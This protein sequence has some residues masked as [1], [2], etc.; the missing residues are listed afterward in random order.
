VDELDDLRD[1]AIGKGLLLAEDRERRLSL[2]A[3]AGGRA[4]CLL[5]SSDVLSVWRVLDALD[6]ASVEA[7]RRDA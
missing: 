3:S 2:Y 1:A 6:L 7:D 4:R 5:S